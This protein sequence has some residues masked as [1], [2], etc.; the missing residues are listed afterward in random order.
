[1]SK[2]GSCR[3][4]TIG[5]YFGDAAIKPCGICD[6]CR[7]KKPATISKDEFDAILHRMLNMVK[8][9]ALEPALLFN[10]MSDVDQE[11]SWKILEYL[12]KENKIEFDSLGRIRMK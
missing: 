4:Q 7:N 9:E 3:S 8:Y 12:Q 10:K 1:M 11:K 5:R 6:N 2:G